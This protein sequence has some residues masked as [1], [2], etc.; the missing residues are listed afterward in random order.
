MNNVD[1]PFGGAAGEIRALLGR[2]EAAYAKR[3]LEGVS[4]LV[5]EFFL[6]GKTPVV[7]GTGTGELFLGAD[8]IE[9]LI[10]SDFRSWGD[11]RLDLAQ[12]RIGLTEKSA[13]VAVPGAVR[14]AFENGA[15]V[16]G[17]LCG[18]VRSAL[19]DEARAPLNRLALV[20]LV[21]SHALH[22]REES[23]RSCW[24]PMHLSG[25]LERTGAGWKFASMQFSMPRESFPDE[26]VEH[27]EAHRA[28]FDAQNAHALE[29]EGNRAAEAGKLLAALERLAGGGDAADAVLREAFS[30]QTCAMGPGPRVFDGI[31]GLRA[32]LAGF[33]GA[34]LSFEKEH[35]LANR[36]GDLLFIVANGML[37]REMDAGELVRREME[38]LRAVMESERADGEKLMRAHALAAE[39]LME[40]SS[41][42]SF[43]WPI[44]LTA[45]AEANGTGWKLAF[46]H[47]SYPFYWILEGREEA[48]PDPL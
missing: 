18:F 17:S 48:L 13:W 14:Y 46:V 36:A 27:T 8:E 9:G 7:L 21:L 23:A 45:A 6:P 5:G 16:D 24:L 22:Q 35:A 38:A 19:A 32:C 40:A 25:A 41:G 37:H 34:K 30:A 28:D 39:A 3:D 44:R 33:E 2:F 12:A 1:Q 20:N 15:S 31:E 26:R 4:R 43:T 47:F 10:R 29:Y 42:A 11:M